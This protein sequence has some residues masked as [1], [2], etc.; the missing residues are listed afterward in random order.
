MANRKNDNEYE[1]NCIVS[2]VISEMNDLFCAVVLENS[3]QWRAVCDAD[4]EVTT[5]VLVLEVWVSAGMLSS[6]WQQGEN[7]TTSR[8]AR[9]Y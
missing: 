1:H 2:G 5:V 9:A 6:F 4:A 8:D 3:K 7:S